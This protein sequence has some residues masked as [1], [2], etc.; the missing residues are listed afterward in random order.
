[1]VYTIEKICEIIR[2]IAAKY[3]I[4][5]IYLFGSYARGTATERSDI[6]LLVDTAGTSLTSLF[7]LGALYCDL[8]EAFQKPVDLITVSSLQQRAQLPSEQDF[9]KAV[10]NEGVKLYDVA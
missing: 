5:A 6:D 7:S 1:M 4:P 2:P 9:R 3:Q 10:M 8:E